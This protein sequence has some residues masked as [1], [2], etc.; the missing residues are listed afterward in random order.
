MC[1]RSTVIGADQFR[2]AGWIFGWHCVGGVTCLAVGCFEVFVDVSCFWIPW[3]PWRKSGL[4]QMDK[5]GKHNH[6]TRVWSKKH[7]EF[8]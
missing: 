5:R 8:C 3:I 6:G 7:L 4:L 2:L 1:F